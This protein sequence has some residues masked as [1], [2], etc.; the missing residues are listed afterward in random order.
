MAWIKTIEYKEAKGKLKALY[1]RVKGPNGNIDN[2]M[3]VH[4]LRPHTLEG[5]MYLYKNVLHNSG[6][7]LPKWF[8]EAIGV[9]V[10]ILNHCD[11]C[12]EHHYTGLKRLLNDDKRAAEIREAFE[13]H[14]K[15]NESKETDPL[16]AVFQGKEQVFMGYAYILTTAP[17]KVN[18]ASIKK[19]K[20]MGITDGEILEVNQ[21]VSYFNYANRTVSGL[22]VDLK[23]DILGLSPGD[24]GNPGNW[25]HA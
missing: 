5:H 25:N 24:S 8:L 17:S 13:K 6:N 3:K 10:S 2:I 11:Y 15:V 20:E 16:K 21:V 12:V 9:Y 18:K 23:S 4:S 7:T 22:G 14:S 19:M 1:D